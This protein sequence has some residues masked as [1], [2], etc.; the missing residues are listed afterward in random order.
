MLEGS[1]LFV[2]ADVNPALAPKS[3]EEV[4]SGNGKPIFIA[5]KVITRERSCGIL[6]Y[7]VPTRHAGTL[8]RRVIR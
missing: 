7:R 8:P 5:L 2:F 6:R 3:L 1:I 4:T